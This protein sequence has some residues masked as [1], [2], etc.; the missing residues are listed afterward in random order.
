MDRWYFVMIY[1]SKNGS[2]NCDL[3]VVYLDHLAEFDLA[4][5]VGTE[6]YFLDGFVGPT[7]TE[8][9]S[10]NYK[11]SAWSDHIGR[12][13]QLSITAKD[14]DFVINGVGEDL[15]FLYRAAPM[16]WGGTIFKIGHTR[17]YL[18]DDIVKIDD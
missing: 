13:V 9:D 15:N 11:K 16:S 1:A 10:S 2:G 14:G 18:Y 8:G 17:G 7:V 12:G 5:C 3:N 6:T 4:G